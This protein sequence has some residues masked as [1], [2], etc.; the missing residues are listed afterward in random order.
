M[1]T[2]GAGVNVIAYYSS[3]VFVVCAFASVRI[4]EALLRLPSRLVSRS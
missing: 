1:L 4:V 2:T 3:E